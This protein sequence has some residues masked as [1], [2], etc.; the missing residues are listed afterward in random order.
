M[1]A[2][3]FQIVREQKDD[4]DCEPENG[5]NPISG[6]KRFQRGDSEKK[7]KH[8]KVC[9]K[10]DFH[11]ITSKIQTGNRCASERLNREI[12][13]LLHRNKIT[14]K[15]RGFRE[16]NITHRLRIISH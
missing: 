9:A 10:S 11:I 13:I 6:L 15:E 4:A 3:F 16:P 5:F 7:Q 12:S 2:R 1:Y 14:D 8:R